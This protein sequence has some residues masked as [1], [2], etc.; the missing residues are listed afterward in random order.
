MTDK[1]AKHKRKMAPVRT[2]CV[3]KEFD[4]KDRVIIEVKTRRKLLCMIGRTKRAIP[5]HQNRHPSLR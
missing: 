5:P 4:N 3:T 2:D 1:N